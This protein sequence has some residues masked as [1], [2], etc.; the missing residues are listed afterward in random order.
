MF[1]AVQRTSNILSNPG[2]HLAS[3]KE[4]G[5]TFF[6]V[7]KQPFSSGFGPSLGEEG[8]GAHTDIITGVMF[9]TIFL[10]VCL[11]VRLRGKDKCVG[12]SHSGF[13]TIR[14]SGAQEG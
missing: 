8:V 9:R 11:K 2:A 4:G 7:L 3:L 5:A 13:G 10:D 14:H 1:H 12:L 6:G